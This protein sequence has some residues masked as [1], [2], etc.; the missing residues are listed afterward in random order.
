VAVVGGVA[1]GTVRRKLR[2]DQQVAALPAHRDRLLAL[3]ELCAEALVILYI[4][5]IKLSNK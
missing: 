5:Y 1:A 4:A 3:E 2:P